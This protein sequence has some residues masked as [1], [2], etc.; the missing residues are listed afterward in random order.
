MAYNNITINDKYENMSFPTGNFSHAK[1][2]IIDDDKSTI[3]STFSHQA[4]NFR[5]NPLVDAANYYCADEVGAKLKSKEAI[6]D[7]FNMTFDQLNET[8]CQEINK[9]AY[10]YV[11]AHWSGDK[12]AL[13]LYD[14]VGQPIEFIEDTASGSGITWVNEGVVYKN[15]TEAW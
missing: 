10:Q 7:H 1:P 11:R 8:T 14:K 9:F 5:T 4:Y 6:Y 13:D 15:T 2:I 12:H 3:I